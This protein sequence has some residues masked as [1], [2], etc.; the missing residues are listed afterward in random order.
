MYRVADQKLSHVMMIASASHF[1]YKKPSGA[2]T[3][4]KSGNQRT[5]CRSFANP[6]ICAF[7]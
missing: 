7:S 2:V 3:M 1:A 5:W 6:S 4:P